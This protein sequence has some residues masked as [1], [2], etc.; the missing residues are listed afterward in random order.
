MNRVSFSQKLYYVVV[1]VSIVVVI[2]RFLSSFSAAKRVEFPEMS[3]AL[4]HTHTHTNSISNMACND[5]DD[6]DDDADDGRV[7]LTCIFHLF[8]E[9]VSVF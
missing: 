1:G 2:I 3:L 8:K 6:D 7:D 5:A 4:A 9:L